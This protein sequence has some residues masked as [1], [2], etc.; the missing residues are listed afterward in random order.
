MIKIL[1]LRALYITLYDL[2]TMGSLFNRMIL[3]EPL[4]GRCRNVIKNTVH[5]NL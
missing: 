4:R 5:I 3:L 1:K 2:Q